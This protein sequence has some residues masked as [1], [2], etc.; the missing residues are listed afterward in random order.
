MNNEEIKRIAEELSYHVGVM[1]E[2]LSHLEEDVD[3]IQKGDAKTPYWNGDN[4][5]K[6]LRTALTQVR[7]DKEI[8]KSLEKDSVYVNSLVK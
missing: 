2:A 8:V 5:S 1:K 6:C 4:A 7:C 3:Q